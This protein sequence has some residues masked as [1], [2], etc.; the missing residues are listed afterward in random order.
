MYSRAILIAFSFA[1]APPFVKKKTSM[2]PGAIDAS[3]SP[4]FARGWD[5]VGLALA[6]IEEVI[7][8]EGPQHIAAFF[9]EPVT[10]TNGILVP[11]AG[12]LEGIRELC[13]KYGILMVA[14]E[15]MSGFGRTGEWF[16]I[17]HWNVVPDLLTMAKGLT[18]AYVPLGAVGMR[19][20]IADHFKNN[21]FFGG[22]TYNSHPLGCAAALATISVYEDENL[23][24]RA[25]KS[26]EV[27]KRLLKDLESRHD[28]VGG[29]RSIGLFGIVELVKSKKTMEPLAPYNGTSEPMTRLAKFFRQE[30]LYT[31]VRWNN[32]FTNP[33]LTIS[34]DELRHGFDI[35]DRGLR[36][37]A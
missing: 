22:L 29:T 12:Y 23:I 6:N 8:Y 31:F 27:M 13:T 32:F 21:V 17:N 7:Q 33:P 9:I 5:E 35:I 16:A 25:K 19:R 24:A 3:F 26:G 34:E 14:D 18:S 37:I 4:S 1:S 10:G 36:E 28:V 2:S 15:V 11:P 30:G 20:A